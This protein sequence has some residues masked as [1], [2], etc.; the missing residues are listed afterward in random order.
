MKKIKIVMVSVA[1]MMGLAGCA[2]GSPEDPMSKNIKYVE[3]GD[4]RIVECITYME[5][6]SCDW[7]NAK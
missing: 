5:G 6:I 4:G 1:L 7:E 3:L 2:G